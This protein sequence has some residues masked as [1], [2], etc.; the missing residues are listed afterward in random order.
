LLGSIRVDSE[1][2]SHTFSSIFFSVRVNF[3]SVWSVE[4]IHDV[5]RLEP[6]LMNSDRSLIDT[7]EDFLIYLFR[8]SPGNF[9][10]GKPGTDQKPL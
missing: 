4:A 10:N 8:N 2:S 7:I 3:F 9:E 1:H 6:E 5:L